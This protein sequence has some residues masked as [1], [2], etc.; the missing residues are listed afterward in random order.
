MEDTIEYTLNKLFGINNRKAKSMKGRT[1]PK[2]LKMY[3]MIC[4]CHGC[5]GEGADPPRSKKSLKKNKFYYPSKDKWS[6]NIEK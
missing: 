3:C 5:K 4:C 2:Y 1:P 6:R